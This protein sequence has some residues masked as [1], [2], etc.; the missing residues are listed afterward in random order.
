MPAK[1]A[2]SVPP[3]QSY[4]ALYIH[5]PFCKTRCRYCD[6]ASEAMEAGGPAAQVHMDTY[7]DDLVLQLRRAA[8]AG[9]LAQLSTVY[10]GGG[11]PSY[12]GGRRLTELLYTLSLTLDL[13]RIEELTLE[14]NPD[15]LTPALV[16][17]SFA[18][19]VD[20]YSL[21]VQSFNDRE[22]A[23][24]GRPHDATQARAAIRLIGERPARLSIDL[25][26]GIPEQNMT[27]WQASLAEATAPELEVSHISVYPLELHPATP[28]GRAAAAGEVALPD[29]DMVADMLAYAADYLSRQGFRHY[30]I[31]SYAK[32]GQESRHNSAYW[33]GRPYLGL[34][35]G[36]WSMRQRGLAAEVGAGTGGRT[37]LRERWC[38][39][40]LQESVVGAEAVAREDA[41]LG[42]RMAQGISVAAQPEPIRQVMSQQIA[43]G[44][45]VEEDGRYRLS[46]RG[47]FMANEVFASL[48]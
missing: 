30:E 6:F 16:R 36:A 15:S 9:E 33:T 39:G 13:A 45:V 32:P 38:D 23:A 31:A 27:S 24:L 14:A 25:M 48:L 20:R 47:L 22:L 12:L 1:T 28:L 26:C 40:K 10:I 19:G 42:L 7:V 43:R 29:E 46:R 34:G 11:T 44:L 4:Q 17:D 37:L 8:K 35:R 5:V 3:W 41:M 2:S 21:G 18:L